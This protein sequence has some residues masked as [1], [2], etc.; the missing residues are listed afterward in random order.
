KRRTHSSLSMIPWLE[1]VEPHM[2]WINSID[3]ELRGVEYGDLVDIYNDR[4]RVRIPANVT[5]RVIPGVV[6]IYQG[7]WYN[8]N[9]EGIDIGGCGNVLTK[10]SRSPGGAFPM[11]SALVQVELYSKKE[12]EGS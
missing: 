9:E 6:V 10:D 8:P 5:E 3:A 2:V 1:E 7:A 11:N 12:S 4:G